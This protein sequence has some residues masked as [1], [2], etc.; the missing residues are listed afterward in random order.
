MSTTTTPSSVL[1]L[2]GSY[3]GLHAAE[4][5]AQQLPSHWTVTLI[6]RNTHFNHV[7]SFPRSVV[8]GH[9]QRNFIPYSAKISKLNQLYQVPG[10]TTPRIRLIN[11]A[12]T[13]I[14]DHRVFL[15]RMV[16]MDEPTSS[17]EPVSPPLHQPIHTS[18]HSSANSPPASVF[19]DSGYASSVNPKTSPPSGKLV[20]P[21]LPSSAN[22][23]SMPPPPSDPA[24]HRTFQVRWDFLVYALGSHMPSPLHLPVDT[25][26]SKPN[27]VAFLEDQK[28]AIAQAHKVVIVGG[29]ALGIQ[30]ASDIAHRYQLLGAPKQVTLI[31][32]RT[33]F[34]PTFQPEVGQK[35][36][37]ALASYGV[38][39]VLGERV[40][41]AKLQGDLAAQKARGSG[42]VTVESLSHPNKR[43]E[44]DMVLVCT[45]QTPNTSLMAQFCPLAVHGGAH[46][47]AGSSG[48]IR[49]NRGLQLSPSRLGASPVETPTGELFSCECGSAALQHQ[50]QQQQ[51]SAHLLKPPPREEETNINPA[52][53]RVFAIGDCVDG[54]GAIK[55]GHVG[56]NQ[57]EVAARN[58]LASIAHLERQPSPLTTDQPACL[59]EVQLEQYVPSPPM[60]KLTLGLNRVVTQLRSPDDPAQLVVAEKTT[61][62]DADASAAWREIWSR[63]DLVT[64]DQ[65]LDGW[66]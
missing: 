65:I 49:V 56:W 47:Y 13:K 50:Q 28:E 62:L 5:L 31:H 32:S 10:K 55:A 20:D 12:V 16:D 26:R 35:V 33:V 14:G 22:I 18:I 40:N 2:G 43:W 60:I 29:G 6:E 36:T 19:T 9:A 34:L 11:A 54:F 44:A 23:E 4:L 42:K 63:Y 15:D 66:A 59:P 41:L 37:Q 61:A 24:P 3:A 45:G 53:S 8:A 57:A 48:L 58:I 64:E 17:T 46:K 38:E 25:L 52:W 39:V 30:Y 27:G 21:A 1:V 7:Y 51:H